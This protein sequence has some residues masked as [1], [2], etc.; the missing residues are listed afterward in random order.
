MSETA[1]KMVPDFWGFL[2]EKIATLNQES[3]RVQ[4]DS[5]MKSLLDRWLRPKGGVLAKLEDDPFFALAKPSA[6]QIF[7]DM[8]QSRVRQVEREWR[9]IWR[10]LHEE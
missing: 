1:A 3:A 5:D 2:Q 8:M 6:Q 7:M 4:S 10:S 9:D